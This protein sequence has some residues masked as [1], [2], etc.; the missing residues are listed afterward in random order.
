MKIV[1]V[2]TPFYY[3]NKYIKNLIKMIEINAIEC[4]KMEYDVEYILVNDSP[5]EKIEIDENKEYTF[6]VRVVNLERNSGIQKARVEGLKKARGEFVLFLDQ[7]DKISN[8]FLIYQLQQ[9]K[10][11]DMCVSRC[12]MQTKTGRKHF[13]YNEIKFND[14][15]LNKQIY[16]FAINPIVS[17]GQVLLRKKAIPKEWEENII[18]RNGAD[19]YFLWILMLENNVK[20]AVSYK[21]MYMH[22]GHLHNTSTDKKM[23]K[24]STLEMIDILSKG[25]MTNLL[26]IVILKASL[27][28]TYSLYKKIVYK[29]FDIEDRLKF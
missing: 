7:D 3:G 11:K 20:I 26:K 15:I 23:M 25:K 12:I 17:P 13:Y 4:K 28:D 21:A 19:D 18:T 16:Y 8:K 6:E 2:I 14:S 27:K 1:S 5:D 22:I 9:I 29:I 24:E 10:D